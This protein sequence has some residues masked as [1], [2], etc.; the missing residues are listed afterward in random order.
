MSL[1]EY[2][3]NVNT[4]LLLHLNGD[5]NDS[6]SNGTNGTSTSITYSQANGKFG[7]GAGFNGASNSQITFASYITPLGAKTVSIWFN[8]TMTTFTRFIGNLSENGNGTGF[9]FMMDT[10][11]GYKMSIS[12]YKSNVVMYTTTSLSTINDGKWNNIIMTW[13]GTT[14]ANGVNIYYNGNLEVSATSNSTESVA[15]SGVLRIG[16]Y[17][18]TYDYTGAIDEVIIENRAWAAQEVK[19]YYTNSIGRFATL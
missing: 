6:S 2:K 14:N 12:A 19:K 4:K 5:A 1:G 17:S 16:R 15:P 13:D 3:Q 9:Q 10:P 7:Q 18:T 8:T 11:A